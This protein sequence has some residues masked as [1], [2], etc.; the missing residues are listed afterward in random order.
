MVGVAISVE[1]VGASVDGK[2]ASVDSGVSVVASVD[3]NVGSVNDV[4]LSVISVVESV[5][6][7]GDASVEGTSSGPFPHPSTHPSPEHPVIRSSHS[8]NC[9]SS[10]RAGRLTSLAR[11]FAF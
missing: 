9:S 5:V 6:V 11:C 2:G 10:P 3:C 8:A 1:R 4:G 7:V